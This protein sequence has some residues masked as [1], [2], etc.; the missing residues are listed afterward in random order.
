MY[1]VAGEDAAV[2]RNMLSWGIVQ[3]YEAQ[4]TQYKL[5]AERVKQQKD[6]ADK[7]KNAPRRRK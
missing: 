1:L 4:N 3:Y 5:L 7:A 2:A 6:A